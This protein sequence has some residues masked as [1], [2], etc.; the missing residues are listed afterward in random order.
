VPDV[1]RPS[2]GT[3]KGFCPCEWVEYIEFH[4]QFVAFEERGVEGV[5]WLLDTLAAHTEEAPSAS[6]PLAWTELV[7][8]V[9]EHNWKNP[10]VVARLAVEV[11]SLFRCRRAL[12]LL[13]ERSGLPSSA[14]E[15]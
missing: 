8:C 5:V 7:R 15:A 2:P 11:E 6:N 4:C 9:A 12:S 13:R 14:V 3:T 1:S 10:V